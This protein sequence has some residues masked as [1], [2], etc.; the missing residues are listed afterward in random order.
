LSSSSY[1]GG[2]IE[3]RPANLEFLQDKY[4]KIRPCPKVIWLYVIARSKEDSFALLGTG[5]AISFY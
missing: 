5:C 1:S 2:D 3:I 4:V